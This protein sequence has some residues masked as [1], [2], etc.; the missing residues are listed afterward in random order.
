MVKRPNGQLT[1]SAKA[2]LGHGLNDIV[3]WSGM[4]YKI[5][6]ITP[7]EVK[8]VEPNSAP[9]PFKNDG[10]RRV[11]LGDVVT[12]LNIT[13]NQR[14]KFIMGKKANGELVESATVFLNH[15]RGEKVRFHNKNYQIIS[16]K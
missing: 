7:P 13:T 4:T 12:A 5:I 11:R 14:E 16:M 9:I 3:Q 15:A 2:C 8:K 6:Q 1:D 10:I